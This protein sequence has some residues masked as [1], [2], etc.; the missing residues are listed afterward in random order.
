M[1]DLQQVASFLAVVR[2]G[3]FVGAADAT[4]FSKAAVSRHV[5]ELEERLGVRLLHRTTRR[6]SLSD[7]GQRFHARAAELI[8]ALDELEAETASSGGEAT[9][10]LRINAPVTFGNLHLAPLWP[11]FTAAHPK[12]ALD[13]TLNDRLVDLVEEGYDLAIRIS[14]LANSQL[15]SRPL[16]TTRVVLCASPGYLTAHGTPTHPQALTDHQVLAYNYWMDGDVW[17][18]TGPDG[19]AEVRVHPRIH[20]NSGDTCRAAALEDQGIILQPDFLVGE[21]LRR[22][23]LVELMPQYRSIEL[24]IHAVYATRKHL[25]MKTRHLVDFLVE[26]FRDVS[27]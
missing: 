13:I 2:S 21:D 12:V 16:A 11:R 14:Q 19:V 22:G 18:F 9:G 24:G 1:L 6:L 5:A 26:S 15:V 23:T 8:A 17:R 3:S 7:D 4:G 10:R 20:S 27:W 25:P